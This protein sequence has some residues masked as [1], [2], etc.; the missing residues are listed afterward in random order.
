MTAGTSR[1]SSDGIRPRANR[2]DRGGRGLP[3]HRGE[4][5]C[6]AAWVAFGIGIGWT[7]TSVTGSVRGTGGDPTPGVYNHPGSADR[8]RLSGRIRTPARRAGQLFPTQVGAPM[9]AERLVRRSDGPPAGRRGR[10][11]PGGVRPVRHAGW[12]G[13]PAHLDDR[14]AARRWTRRTWSSRRTRASSSGQRDGGLEVGGWDGLW[15]VLTAHH[16]AEVCRPGRVL[17][18]RRSGTCGREVGRPA[19]RP[20]GPAVARLRPRPRPSA[21]GGGGC[22]PRR[23][24]SCSGPP[25][26]PG[27]AGRSWT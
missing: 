27:R 18:G 3:L 2:G 13:W 24:R 23:S 10:G 15:G 14:L 17:T 22:W 12:S 8:R 6:R 21:G 7:A 1:A 9:S 20:L 16:P 25:G 5:T 4:R 19:R 11:R 26:R